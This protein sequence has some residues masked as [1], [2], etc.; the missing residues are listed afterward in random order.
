MRS[1][2]GT[3]YT[4]ECILLRCV[5]TLLLFHNPLFSVTVV[6]PL[7]ELYNRHLLPHTTGALIL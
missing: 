1:I 6:A 5:Q 7:P 2:E 4:Q 3:I